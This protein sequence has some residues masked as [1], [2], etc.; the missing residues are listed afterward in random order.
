MQNV[1]IGDPNLKP[2]RAPTR[3]SPMNRR[4]DAYILL[5]VIVILLIAVGVWGAM[6]VDPPPAEILDRVP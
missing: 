2:Q 6:P 3:L 4:R 5:V 1:I